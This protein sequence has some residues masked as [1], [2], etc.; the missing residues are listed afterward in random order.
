MFVGGVYGNNLNYPFIDIGMG[1][2]LPGVIAAEEMIL[3]MIDDRTRIFADQGSGERKTSMQASHDM[4][5]AVRDRV[6][7]LIDDGKSEDE[8]VAARPTQDFD[9]TW[10]RQGSFFT[11]EIMTRQVYRSL[12]ASRPADGETRAESV[13]RSA[14][15]ATRPA[16]A[17]AGSG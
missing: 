11:G 14:A 10:V 6:Q 3:P 17:P 16:G 4:L 15:G 8:A 12:K 2:S 5:V 1:G 7:R 13:F 9:K